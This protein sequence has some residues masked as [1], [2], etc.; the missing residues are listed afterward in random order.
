MT[1]M[2]KMMA[3]KDRVLSQTKQGY[4]KINWF[5]PQDGDQKIRILPH[6]DNL[7]MKSDKEPF[8]EILVHFVSTASGKGYN[9]R[10]ERD[11]EAGSACPFCQKYDELLKEGKK[12]AAFAYRPRK[13]AIANIL[14]YSQKCVQPYMMP[15]TVHKQVWSYFGDFGNVFSLKE[16]RDFKLTKGKNPAKAGR[17]AVEYQIIP[18][19]SESE[20]PAKAMAMI[21]DMEPI[22]KYYDKSGVDDMKKALGLVDGDSDE[23][24]D[25]TTTDEWSEE[26]TKT[27]KATAKTTVTA[28]AKTETAKPTTTRKAAP[29]ATESDDLDMDDEIAR[30]SK[31]LGDDDDD[32]DF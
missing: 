27:T 20:V 2:D 17:M 24:F 11:R 19:A 14:N 4:E 10:C 30:L 26:E 16:G 8:H 12:E 32:L 9:V 6:V 3:K 1:F 31:D 18:L 13:V 5:K 22:E 21:E 29:V 25:D 15:T 28:K 23:D 7:D